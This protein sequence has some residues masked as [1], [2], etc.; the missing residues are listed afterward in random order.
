MAL[1]QNILY[2]LALF[3]DRLVA[4]FSH[5]KH[6]YRDRFAH[7]HELKPLLT[8][9]LDGTHLLLGESIFNHVL[10]VSP[11]ETEKDLANL[12]IIGRTGCGKSAHL[13]SQLLTWPHSAIVNDIKGEL[14]KKTAGYRTTLG[15]VFVIN[16]RGFG[17]QFDPLEGRDSEDELYISAELLMYEPHEGDGKAFTQRATKMLTLLFL[18]AREVNRQAGKQV[19]RLLPFVADMADLGLNSAAAR[20]N[21]I[22][23]L[24]ARRFLDGEY[25]AHKDYEENKFLASSWESL[26]ARLYPLLTENI[27]RC[28]NGSDFTGKDIISAKKPIT[29]YFCWRESELRAKAP[30]ITL[31]FETLLKDM[32]DAYDDVDGEGCRLVL[33]AL[34]ELGRTKLPNLSDHVATVRSRGISIEGVVQSPVQLE[35][36]YGA[37]HAR[38]IRGN[39]ASK[40]FYRPADYEEA[41][42]LQKWLGEKSGF[43]HSTNTHGESNTSKGL[44]EREVAVMTA[45]EIMLLDN[46]DIVGFRS[47]FRWFRARRMEWWRFPLLAKRQAITPPPL[48]LLPPLTPR[49]PQKAEHTPQPATSWRLEPELIRRGRP[50][51]SYNAY[52]KMRQM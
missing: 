24:I 5:E 21:A 26:T 10:A 25:N 12:L 43:A 46:T 1:L 15:D 47:G 23:P 27:V 14:Y 29:V 50:S 16:T 9:K 17:H 7:R 51:P 35:A 22:S 30:L 42:E 41:L 4:L 3:V 11:T 13:I 6:L 32:I 2:R 49:E 39:M 33:T 34:D 8:D 20:L 52:R 18:A 31:I 44:S 36:A 48:P 38:I 45:Q 40:I 37:Y 19:Y 28:F